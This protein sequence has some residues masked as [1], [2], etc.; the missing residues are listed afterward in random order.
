MRK[1]FFRIISSLF[2][3]FPEIFR[4]MIGEW[5]PKEL[6]FQSL[7]ETKTRPHAGQQTQFSAC[8]SE[9]RSETLWR[10]PKKPP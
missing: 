1:P 8:A 7:T 2:V 5:P 3:A 4:Q 10:D 9:P 6:A